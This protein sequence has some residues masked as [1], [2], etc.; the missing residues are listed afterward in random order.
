MKAS[1]VR[2][3]RKYV[4]LLFAIAFVL[5]SSLHANCQSKKTETKEETPLTLSV[6][7][8][9][10]SPEKYLKK[11]VQLVGRL[12]NKGKNYFTDLSIVLRDDQGNH[13]Y[14]RPWLPIELPPSPPGSTRKR[15]AV[16]S[17][18]LG[19][20]VELTAVLDRGTLKKVGEVYLLSVI[21][22]KAIQ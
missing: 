4:F 11:T 12:E 5:E 17:Q 6:A 13:V 9:V 7:S 15:P 18:Y 3:V 8:I 10:E 19:K 22:A 1:M 20:Q 2:Q 21:S 16:L 14:V